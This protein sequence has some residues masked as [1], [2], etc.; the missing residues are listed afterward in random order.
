MF[1]AFIRYYCIIMWWCTCKILPD[2]FSPKLQAKLRTESLG[3][4]LQ[5][6]S[7]IPHSLTMWKE[8][9]IFSSH[10]AQEWDYTHPCMHFH[11]SFL[12]LAHF[13]ES[14]MVVLPSILHH[15]H[16]HIRSHDDLLEKCLDSLGAIL[17]L[18]HDQEPVSWRTYRWSSVWSCPSCPSSSLTFFFYFS[19]FFIS[20]LSFFI[21]P[22]HSSSLQSHN[23]SCSPV[24]SFALLC[25]PPRAWLIKRWAW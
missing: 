13:Q 3:W 8:E 9:K 19:P 14:R 12:F 18:L 23:S 1:C 6:T 22:F 4:R 10:T 20:S 7:S 21:H 2:Y 5:N 15:L 17:I 11:F 24:S 25:P 16:Y